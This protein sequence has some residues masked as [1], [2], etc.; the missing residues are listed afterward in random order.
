MK[1]PRRNLHKIIESIT[2]ARSSVPMAARDVGG[3]AVQPVEV[4]GQVGLV[5]A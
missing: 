1:T 3:A 4:T 2:A 5:G